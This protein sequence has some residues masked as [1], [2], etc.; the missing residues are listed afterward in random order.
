[1][2][3]ENPEVGQRISTLRGAGVDVDIRRAGRVAVIVCLVALAVSV[4]VLF[5]AGVQKNAQINRLRQHGVPVEVTVSG[6]LGLLG[7]SGSNAA[8][9]SC[10]GSFTLDGRRYSDAIPGNTFY[11][12]QQSV[13]AITDPDNPALLSTAAIVAG[14]RASWTVFALP[15][16]LLVVLAL[17]VAVV[18]R[19]RRSRSPKPANDQVSGLVA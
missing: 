16:T 7:G 8:G 18:L 11:R 15:G 13:R 10:R 9:Y 5:T 2:Q 17:L 1:M 3:V 12:P 4:V 6:C 14:E 19:R